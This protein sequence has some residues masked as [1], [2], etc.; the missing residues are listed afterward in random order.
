MSIPGCN[1]VPFS[2]LGTRRVFIEVIGSSRKAFKVLE[3]CVLVFGTIWEEGVGNKM[4]LLTEYWWMYI[5]YDLSRVEQSTAGQEF[6]QVQ[7]HIYIIFTENKGFRRGFYHISIGLELRFMGHW[8][9]FSK[10]LGVP[11]PC[12]STGESCAEITGECEFVAG[13]SGPT[14]GPRRWYRSNF[15]TNSGPIPDLVVMIWDDS[16]RGSTIRT[17]FFP[18]NS[19]ILSFS[20]L[21]FLDAKTLQAARAS[22]EQTPLQLAILEGS[23]ASVD[24]SWPFCITWRGVTMFSCSQSILRYQKVGLTLNYL[25]FLFGAL[26][27]FALAI[28]SI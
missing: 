23:Q 15:R 16:V 7:T 21:W 27:F 14:G 6:W 3:R 19:V 10:F 25:A 11:L 1:C 18:W 12:W 4:Q 2:Y 20:P 8:P 26:Y 22:D 17:W 24:L 5:I 9:F 13:A 28:S